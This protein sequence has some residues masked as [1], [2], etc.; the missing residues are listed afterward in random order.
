MGNAVVWGVRST[1]I[2][3]AIARAASPATVT[4][5][6]AEVGA[7]TSIKYPEIMGT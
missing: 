3:G 1:G 4:E 6:C 2:T 5:T 7:T